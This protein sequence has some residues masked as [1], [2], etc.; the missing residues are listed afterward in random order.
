MTQGAYENYVAGEFVTGENDRTLEVENPATAETVAL[1]ALAGAETCARAVEAGRAAFASGVLSR[2]KPTVRMRL[3]F[4]IA[5]E[6]RKVKQEGGRMLCLEQGK[7]LKSAEDEFEKAAAAFEYYGGL[8]D[9]A[10]GRQIPLGDGMVDFTILEPLG[11]SL[12]IVPW[13]FPVSIAAR[14]V[15]AALATGNSV[16]L[17]S[18]EITPVG[19]HYMARAIDAAG[20]PAGTVSVICATGGDAGRHLVTDPAIDQITFTGSV[21]TG[22]WILSAAAENIVPTV[23]ELGGKSAGIALDDADMSKVM[24]A[25]RAST[26]SNAGQICSGMTRLIVHRSRYDEALAELGKLAEEITVGPGMDNSVLTPLVSETQRNRVQEYLSIGANEKLDLVTGGGVPDRAGWF[27]DFTVYADVPA[28]SRL[29]QEEIFGPVLVVMPF[30]TREE[31]VEL[32]NGTQYGLAA[33]IFTD[34]L[35][36]ALWLAQRLRAGQVYGN[37]WHAASIASPFGGFGRSGFGRERGAE[38]VMNYAKSK[39]VCFALS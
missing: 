29:A 33:G 2:A 4:D 27:M 19:L 21:A 24:A 11:L 39:N 25:V 12:Q 9:K 36:D 13:N 28:T 15:A 8:A 1:H 3:L 38:A 31:A 32:A 17:K 16:I 5:A 22:R 6:L 26:I 7:S 14:S 34:R 23:M 30:D 18:P 20:A 35:N 10:E 37:L